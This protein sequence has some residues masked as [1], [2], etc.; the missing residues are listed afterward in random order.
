MLIDAPNC[1]F[2]ARFYVYDKTGSVAPTETA[3]S[4]SNNGCQATSP[5]FSTLTQKPIGG[6]FAI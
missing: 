5:S 1:F 2:R 4:V 6:P 3:T